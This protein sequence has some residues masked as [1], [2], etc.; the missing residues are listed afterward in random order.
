MGESEQDRAAISKVRGREAAKISNPSERMSYIARQ[1]DAE[2]RER[3]NK[4]RRVQDTMPMIEWQT[5]HDRA[6]KR[7]KLSRRAR[8]R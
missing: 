7:P 4:L 5:Y 6:I 8:R 2:S 3:T 1:G